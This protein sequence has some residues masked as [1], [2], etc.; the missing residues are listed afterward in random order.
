[1]SSNEVEVL[2]DAKEHFTIQTQ[3]DLFVILDHQLNDEL[4]K[5]GYA[6]EFVSN[7]QQMRRSNNYEVA[8]HIT[9]K[10][11]STPEFEQ[12]IEQHREFIMGEVLADKMEVAELLVDEVVL[13]NQPTKIEIER[14]NA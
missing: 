11:Q 7:V 1:M 9:I 8:D 4:I 5:E 2:V 10:Y 3:E 13:N 6:R 14:I 12:A